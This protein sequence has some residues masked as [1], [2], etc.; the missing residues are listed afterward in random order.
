MDEVFSIPSMDFSVEKGPD[1][2]FHARGCYR[3]M[4]VIA[5]SPIDAESKC[6]ILVDW[7]ANDAF[8]FENLFCVD[9]DGRPIWVAELPGHHDSFVDF[10]LTKDTLHAHTFAGFHL[11]LDL[12]TGRIL[13]KEFAK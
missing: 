6:I 5:A 8:T 7:M 11:T 10:L 3:R 12:A 1:G 4:K 2:R 13:D 9:R